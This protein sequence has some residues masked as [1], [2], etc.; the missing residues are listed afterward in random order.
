[1]D[2]MIEAVLE[3]VAVAGSGE[4]F[5]LLLKTRRSEFVPIT[6]GH[7]EAMSILAG[8]ASEKLSRPLSHDLMLDAL[9]LLGAT[10]ERVE[11]TELVTTAEGGTFYGKVVLESRGVEVELD[12]RPSDALALAVRTGAPIWVAETVVEQVGMTDFGGGVEA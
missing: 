3:D 1:M 8:R 6:I 11:V 9:E 4:F 10:L 7:L 2:G 5:I 12:A